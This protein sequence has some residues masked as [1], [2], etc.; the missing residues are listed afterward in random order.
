MAR[1]RYSANG[2]SERHGNHSG[3]SLL[4]ASIHDGPLLHERGYP[5]RRVGHPA[6]PWI[7]RESMRCATIR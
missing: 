3:R 5:F 7:A 4:G 2:G 6:A 1:H